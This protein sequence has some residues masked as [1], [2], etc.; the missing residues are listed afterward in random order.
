MFVYCSVLTDSL[1]CLSVEVVGDGNLPIKSIEFIVMGRVFSVCR[2]MITGDG[3]G[4]LVSMSVKDFVLAVGARTAAPGGG[5][6]AALCASL[7]CL[8]CCVICVCVWTFL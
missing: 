4:P 2:Y 5:S 3:D 6:V 8:L 7:V 1:M